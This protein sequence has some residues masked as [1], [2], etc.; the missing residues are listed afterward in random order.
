MQ[1]APKHDPQIALCLEWYFDKEGARK[2]GKGT[3]GERT[4][5]E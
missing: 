4:R 1:R 5:G 2:K 3:K